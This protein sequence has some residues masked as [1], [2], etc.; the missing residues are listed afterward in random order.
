[1][2]AH[3]GYADLVHG[4]PP[5]GG[6]RGGDRLL[7]A[8]EW[9]YAEELIR[10]ISAWKIL[11]V[12]RVA[13]GFDDA[14][15]ERLDEICEEL[16]QHRQPGLTERNRAVIRQVLADGVW[17]R[18]MQIPEL[19]MAEAARR[20]NHSPVRA[21]A[22]AGV[23]VALQILLDAPI[24]IGN[25]ASARIGENLI[26]PGGARGTYWLVFPDYDVKNRIPLEFELNALTS[27]L[28][29]RYLDEFRPKLLRGFK[30]D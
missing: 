9:R 26:R 12:A 8:R 15:P 22:L 30:G 16:D 17:R 20:H 29:D 11:S 25:L 6:R 13:G 28:I 27:A 21:A 10:L 24:R 1:M 4:A 2:R 23:A 19:L 18:V 7:L 5:P 14:T 3:I